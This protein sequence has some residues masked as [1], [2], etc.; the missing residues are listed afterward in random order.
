MS[1]GRGYMERVG[2]L[3]RD[4]GKTEKDGR[5]V[6]TVPHLSPSSSEKEMD[7]PRRYESDKVYLSKNLLPQSERSHRK[8]KADIK[9][10]E[11]NW[12]VSRRF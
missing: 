2:L 4:R 12:S 1:V 3:R 6:A 7:S 5:R 11:R 10:R 9:N 8:K